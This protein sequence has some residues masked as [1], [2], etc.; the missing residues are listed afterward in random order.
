MDMDFKVAEVTL[1]Y[2]PLRE[3]QGKVISSQEAYNILLPTFREGTIEYREY[4]KVLYLNQQCELVAY[5]T[6]SEGGISETPVD[7][8]TIMQGA[9]LT[10]ATQII[11]AHNHPSG[12]LNPSIQD[13]HLT[14]RL[15]KACEIMRINLVDHLIMTNNGYYSYKDMGRI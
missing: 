11:F 2:K 5:N 15:R 9:L 10:N 1:Q 3:K 12:N 14:E 4:A 7:V 13:D 6:V 8:R